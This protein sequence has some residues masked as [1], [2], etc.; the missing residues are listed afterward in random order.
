MKGTVSLTGLFAELGL[1]PAGVASQVETGRLP[2][3]FGLTRDGEPTWYRM[4]IERSRRKPRPP[5]D[6]GKRFWEMARVVQEFRADN[7]T[8]RSW[9]R[10]GRLPGPFDRC[11]G[12]AFWNSASVE[13]YRRQRPHRTG[14]E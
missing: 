7:Q 14:A 2:F 4:E 9:V 1:S 3:P 5:W 10:E 12:R 8:I 6:A 11:A 13:F